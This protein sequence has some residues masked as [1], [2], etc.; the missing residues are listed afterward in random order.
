M[1]NGVHFLLSSTDPAADQAALNTILK[2]HSVT[3]GEGRLILALPPAEIATHTGSRS[4]VHRH[5]DHDLQGLIAYLMCDDLAATVQTLKADG[6]TCT[7]IEESE[8]GLKTTILLPSG[9]E[10]GLY[11]PS[12]ETPMSRAV[13]REQSRPNDVQ[14]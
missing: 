8:F 14:A 11:Q 5:A 10:L 4:F 1:I 13:G 2:S 9:G 7:E 3:A 12:H 6:F